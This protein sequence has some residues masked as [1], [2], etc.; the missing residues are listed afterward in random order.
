MRV[1]AYV[2]A[3]VCVC[4]CVCVCLC[5]CLC[6]CVCVRVRVCEEILLLCAS[7]DLS[8][9]TLNPLCSGLSAKMPM[10]SLWYERG[11]EREKK[12]REKERRRRERE[13][14]RAD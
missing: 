8:P 4:V 2:C 5:E 6:V 13:G 12:E 10:E 1:C 11:R 9:L 3:C 14:R 7:G